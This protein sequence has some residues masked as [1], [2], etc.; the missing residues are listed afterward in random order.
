MQDYAARMSI[1]LLLERHEP[2][3][4][5]GLKRSPAAETANGPMQ[6]LQ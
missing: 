2:D 5:P 6:A 3:S 1:D 4:P